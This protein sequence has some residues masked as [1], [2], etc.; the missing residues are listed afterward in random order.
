MQQR[1]RGLWSS[2]CRGK[3]VIGTVGTGFVLISICLSLT[4]C[5]TI[6][7]AVPALHS[8]D[9]QTVSGLLMNPVHR[10]I[11]PNTMTAD[12]RNRFCREKRTS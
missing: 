9:G 4:L 3:A 5:S 7:N 2:G 1:V 6:I 12:R 8:A 11:W 10:T